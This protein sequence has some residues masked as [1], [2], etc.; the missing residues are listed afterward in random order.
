[1]D[2]IHLTARTRV[3]TLWLACL[4]VLSGCGQ[5]SGR[6][7][8]INQRRLL[9]DAV[10]AVIYRQEV[11]REVYR[12]AVPRIDEI[13]GDLSRPLPERVQAL[14]SLHGSMVNEYEGSGRLVRSVASSCSRLFH[15]WEERIPTFQND[16]YRVAR[17][18]HLSRSRKT[19]ERT[20]VR[21][22]E[23]QQAVR[24]VLERFSAQLAELRRHQDEDTF[25]EAGRKLRRLRGEIEGLLWI[26]ASSI[27]QSN[28]FV[29]L[30]E[31]AILEVPA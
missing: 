16:S 17:E 28:D 3:L 19:C 24:P 4:L 5:M 18:V 13:L 11:M 27:N 31:E 7:W 26:L 12:L 9:V 22:R 1:M 2:V 15:L 8:E 10:E 23:A 14:R 29:A 30:I 21:M 20:L 25:I 6:F